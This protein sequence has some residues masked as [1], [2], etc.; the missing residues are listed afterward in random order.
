MHVMISFTWQ[1][2]CRN[3]IRISQRQINDI[4]RVVNG[5]SPAPSCSCELHSKWFINHNGHHI[6]CTNVVC[7]DL[8]AYSDTLGTCGKCHCNQIVTVSRGRLVPNL[9]F[10][11]CQKCHCMRGVTVNSVSECGEISIPHTDGPPCI[12]RI[13]SFYLRKRTAP[14]S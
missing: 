10:G 9:S 5:V 1:D 6:A 13:Q 11:T 4:M 14:R 12:S 2:C 8:P 3:R 7:T